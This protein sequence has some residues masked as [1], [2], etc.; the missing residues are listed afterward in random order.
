MSFLL[1]ALSLA[2]Q[3]HRTTNGFLSTSLLFHASVL[4]HFAQAGSSAWNALLLISSS[5]N[6]TPYLRDA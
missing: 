6:L 1:A 4:V 5:L 3:P 2:K